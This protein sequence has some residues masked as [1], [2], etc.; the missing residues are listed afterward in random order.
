MNAPGFAGGWLRVPGMPVDLQGES[1]CSS[2]VDVKDSE[3]QGRYREVRSE[4][5]V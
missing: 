1:P 4:G 2:E 3:A 5:S